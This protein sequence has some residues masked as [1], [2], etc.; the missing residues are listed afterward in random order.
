MQRIVTLIAFVCTLVAYAEPLVAFDFEGTDATTGW[1]HKSNT[2]VTTCDPGSRQGTAALRFVIDP[3]EFNYGWVHLPLPEADFAAAAGV[4]GFFRAPPGVGG[5]ML[6]HL[7]PS[8]DGGASYFEAELGGLQDSGGEWIEFYASIRGMRYQRGEQRRLSTADLGPRTRLQFLASVDGRE[9]TAVDVD[10]VAI[11]TEQDAGGIAQRISRLRVQRMLLLAHQ[12]SEA[13]HPRLLLTPD[14]L[15]RARRKARSGNECQDAYERLLALAEQYLKSYDADAPLAPLFRFVEETE[16]VGHARRGG[17]EGALVPRVTPIET[18]AAAYRLTEDRRFGEHAAKALANAAR[19]LTVWDP[20]IDQGFFY[21]RTFYVRA[22]AFGYD[23]LWELLSPEDRRDVKTVLLG[24]V[25]DIHERSQSDGWGRRPLHRVWNWDPGLMGACGVGL[26]ALEG[27]T[28]CA[29]KAILFDCRRHVRDYLTLGIDTDGCGHEGPN[30]IGYG[31]GPAVEFVE[32]LRRQGRGDLFTETNYQLIPA[33]LTAEIL[34]GGGRWNNLSDCGHGQAPYPVYAYACGRFA[35]LA[36]GEPPRP[37]ERWPSSS[38]RR[39]HEYLAQF[40]EAPGRRPLSYGSLSRLMAWAWEQGP[41]RNDV[42]GYDGPRALAH[43]LFYR[44][45]AA[46]VDPTTL[47]PLGLHF[48]GRGLVVCRT[49]FGGEDFH[50]AVEG[51]PHAAGHDQCDKGTFTLRA[52]GADLV[53]DSGYG[54]DGD[55]RKSGSSHAHNVVLIDGEGQPMRYHNQS[56]G[57]ITGFHHSQ[58]F[59]WIRVDAREAWGVRY[60][61]DWRPLP[62][63]PVLRAER[64]FL[65]VRPGQD[66]PGYVVVFDHTDKDGVE[67]DYTWQWHAP[68]GLRFE[69]EQTRWRA[70]PRLSRYAVLTSTPEQEQAS[71]R[72]GFTVEKTGAYRLVGLVRA[73]GE[74]PGKSD[75]FFVN[76]DDGGQILWDLGATGALCWSPVVHRGEPAPREFELTTGAHTVTLTLRE[77]QS[78]L[79]RLLVLPV[80]AEIPADPEATPEGAIALEVGDEKPSDAPFT[81]REAGTL[82]GP[83]TGMVVFPVQPAGGRVDTDWFLTSREGSHPRLQYTVRG[84]GAR[85][86]MVLL[87]RRTNT[88]L[89]KVVPIGDGS[90][91]GAAI[92]WGDTRDVVAFT[93]GNG[94]AGRLELDGSAGFVRSSGG[95]VVAWG[96]LD[97]TRLVFAGEQLAAAP[98]P[99]IRTSAE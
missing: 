97:G 87:P 14:A 35:E 38:C 67:R 27:E 53:V 3:A 92:E 86:L 40:S 4:H 62:T 84:P 47:L 54:N 15:P 81:R 94:R 71:A 29:E 32:I 80:E 75:S 70:E 36:P 64:A 2:T 82:T 51:G 22:L 1:V 98:Q 50:L 96:L 23:W 90:T 77:R 85:F 65:F 39:P 99:V 49:G 19:R 9:P 17:V 79:A 69:P 73:G 18:M 12:V 42:G 89:P 45:L 6:M 60:D 88:P 56:S 95:R 55:P 76:V 41:G 63:S 58:A 28:R 61:G 48:R 16:L 93:D 21:T 13:A 7:I 74:D 5:R 72:F 43:V 46:A 31:M 20:V 91:A 30:Y 24:F 8:D 78:E 52:Y 26:L 57:S 25:L 33:W 59:D 66:L 83:D 34:P 10:D 37:G 11:L 68:A 44:P